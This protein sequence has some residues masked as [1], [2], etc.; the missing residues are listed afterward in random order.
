MGSGPITSWEIDGETVTDIFCG[1]SKIMGNGDCS[2]EIKR[3]LLLGRNVMTKLDSMLRSRAIT[4]PTKV[5]DKAMVFPIVMYGCESWTIKKA[6]HRRTDAFELWCWRRLLRVPCTARSSNQ[7]ILKEVS[8]QYSLEDLM[9]KL[10][11][12]NFDHLMQRTDSFEKILMLG[13]IEGRRRRGQ[14]RMKWLG[15]ITQCTWVWVNSGSCWWTGKPGV[16]QS[17]GVTLNHWTKLINIEVHLSFWIRVFIFLGHMPRSGIAASLCGESMLSC[18][19]LFATP[20]T[21]ALQ[22]LLSMEF[23]RQ[24]YWSGLPF[25]SLGLLDHMVALFLVILRKLHTVLHIGCTNLHSWQQCTRAP[26]SSL[27]LQNL[28]VDFLV[29]AILS[30]VQ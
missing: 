9:L 23:P 6:E 10:K 13:Q 20:W 25:P 1:G 14:E 24:E 26:F 21:V 29:I 18:V 12:H 7:S 8:P 3:C 4:L 27:P 30:R 5:L 11:S 15:G 28:S 17:M 16:L 22:I 19:S 2:H